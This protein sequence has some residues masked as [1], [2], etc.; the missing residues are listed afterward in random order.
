MSK[1]I[2][3]YANCRANNA[4]GDFV[5]AGNL[6]VDI[7]KELLT[8]ESDIQVVLTTTLDGLWKFHSLYGKPID[9]A[10]TIDKISIQLIP[11]E[12]FDNVN[13]EVIAYVDANHC[14]YASADLV[15]R[16]LSPESKL[17]IIG[18]PNSSSEQ[19]SKYKT[20][21]FQQFIKHQPNLYEYFDEKDMQIKIVGID[22][23]SIGLTQLSK[24]INLN[25]LV[26]EEKNKIPEKPY[27]FIYLNATNSNA[28]K[29]IGDYMQFAQYNQY[30]LVGD[31]V[32]N[33]L[34]LEENIKLDLGLDSQKQLP[35]TYYQS[36]NNKTMKVILANS[37]TF[38]STTGT[39]S[40]LEAMNEG[41][42]TFY[43]DSSNNQDFVK[44]YLLAVR[45]ISQNSKKMDSSMSRLVSLL[46][47]CLFD[48]KPLNKE[49]KE[50]LNEL[51]QIEDLPKNLIDINHQI[52]DKAN[53]KVA[54]HLLNFIG[55]NSNQ[56]KEKQ[57]LK[58]CYNLRK[59]DEK[60]NPKLDQALRRAA[61]WGR[62]FEL[63]ILLQNITKEEV[64]KN[65]KQTG[66]SALHWAVKN[67]KHDCTELLIKF[68][69]DVDVQDSLGFTPLAYAIQ[70]EDK[71]SIKTLILSGASLD[72]EDTKGNKPCT[73][74]SN[75]L[76]VFIESCS[77]KILKII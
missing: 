14:K 18:A 6:A 70:L 42:L 33:K 48:K 38:V 9:N 25:E 30:V 63:K 72:I 23:K 41:K 36:L 21:F 26:D 68:G 39:M 31:F 58:A 74:V 17:L 4:K 57:C 52:I 11:L 50:K 45:S 22:E 2:L 13:N 37:Q 27:G 1:I 3:I 64:N 77:S 69:A 51:S 8:F 76:K 5:L 32:N 56:S 71:E 62:I 24:A 59:T 46:A 15:K 55:G 44:S 53:G 67:K 35:I 61:A 28:F 10:L 49:T 54:K 29:V 34:K 40:T 65:E 12:L 73:K 16:V 66:L 47:F 43:Q 7:A 20:L 60:E 19:T 75:E